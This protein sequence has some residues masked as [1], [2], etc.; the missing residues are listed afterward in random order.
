MQKADA[1]TVTGERGG[2]EA[3]RDTNVDTTRV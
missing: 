1:E 3:E 2:G